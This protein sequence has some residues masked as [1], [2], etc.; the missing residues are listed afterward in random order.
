MRATCRQRRREVDGGLID[1]VADVVRSRS[2]RRQSSAGQRV[3]AR[4]VS[5]ITQPRCTSTDQAP[6]LPVRLTANRC[7]HVC[8]LD[9]ERRRQLN[10]GTP[11][12]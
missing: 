4:A 6:S 12:H 9:P 8:P 3:V 2:H 10:I 1:V 11:G 5:D 7:F